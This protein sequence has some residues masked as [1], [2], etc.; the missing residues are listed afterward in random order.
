[1]NITIA[2]YGFVGKAHA[3]LLKQHYTVHIVDPKL[4]PEM[5]IIQP[6]TLSLFV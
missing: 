4:G 2:G 3:E 5:C 6:V 1:M